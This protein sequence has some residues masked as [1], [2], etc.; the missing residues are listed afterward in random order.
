M[1]FQYL[2]KRSR[3]SEY[4]LQSSTYVLTNPL[5]NLN[6]DRLV[7]RL[8]LLLLLLLLLVMLLLLL[9]LLMLLYLSSADCLH[10]LSSID[11]ARA[12]S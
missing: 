2:R 9:L 7:Y 8:L 1:L 11:T 10:H 5:L 6:Y 3:L 12:E 4:P